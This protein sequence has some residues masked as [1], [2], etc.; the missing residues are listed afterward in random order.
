MQEVAVMPCSH[1]DYWLMY[2]KGLYAKDVEKIWGEG[3][4]NSPVC[5]W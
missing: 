5:T 2:K 1:M 4:K 3:G